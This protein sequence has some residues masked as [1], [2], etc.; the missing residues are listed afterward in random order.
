MKSILWAIVLVASIAGG[1]ATVSQSDPPTIIAE[2]KGSSLKWIRLAEPEFRREKLDL[3]K[4]TVTVSEQNESVTVGLKSLDS[5]RGW[6][7]SSGSYPGFEVE[8]R[9]KDLRVV[10]SNYIR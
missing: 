6:K 4:Y 9:K 2:I 1:P 5:I 3:E 7:G 10:R 8:I